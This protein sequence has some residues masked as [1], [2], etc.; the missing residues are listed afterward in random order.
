MKA[1]VLEQTKSL[2]IKEMNVYE[3]CGPDEVRI[4]IM[5][6]GICG[7][8][9]HYYLH[10]GIG[11]YIVKEPMILGHEASGVVVET[12]SEV[13]NLKAGDRVCM[14]PG[15]PD[16]G[17]RTSRMG[18]Y[19]LDPAV[20]FWA[21]PPIHGCLCETVVHPASYTYKLPVNVSYE[22]GAMVEPLAIGLQ[23][24]D[25]AGIS[26]GDTALVTGCGT[27]GILTAISALAGG[28]S[29]VF[30]SDINTDKLAIT[31]KYRNIEPINL[32]SED[33]YDR[34]MSETDGWGVD[35]VFE[36]SGSAAAIKDLHRYACP[37][38]TLILVGIPAGDGSASIS[39]TGMQAKELRAE[40]V[41]RYAHKYD[42]AVRLIA[43]GDVDVKPL[44]ASVYPFEKSVEA[45]DAASDPSSKAVKIQIAMDS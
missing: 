21:T 43:S 40:T 33:L 8:D 11:D 30:I 36:A 26:P 28:C 3:T 15:I 44:I 31:E 45:F 5:N 17:S 35:K 41:F 1:L 39:I 10:G 42:R 13:R 2:A 32:N 20:R 6:V 24:A 7:S 37:G 19:N 34:I 27:I 23:G 14:E 29:R 12:G 16:G 18:M 4:K 25:K 22:E 38:G 9:V